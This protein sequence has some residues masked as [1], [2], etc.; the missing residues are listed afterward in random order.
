MWKEPIQQYLKPALKELLCSPTWAK[1]AHYHCLPKN[2]AIYHCFEN[3]WG[4]TIFWIL[5]FKKIKFPMVLELEVHGKIL[6]IFFETRVPL[7]IFWIL[8]SIKNFLTNLKIIFSKNS[9][10]WNSSY[11]ANSSFTNS[12]FKKVV[13]PYIFPKQ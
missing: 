9:S 12:S 5:D 2:L 8:S 6:K 10:F 11:K 4:S 7:K 1:M 3:M 13:D